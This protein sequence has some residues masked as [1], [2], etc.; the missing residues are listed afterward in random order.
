MNAT[1]FILAGLMFLISDP[2]YAFQIPDAVTVS[3]GEF[4]VSPYT[5]R[6][7][8]PFA[9]AMPGDAERAAQDWAPVFAA[10]KKT[11]RSDHRTQVMK[12]PKGYRWVQQS[13]GTLIAVPV[14]TTAVIRQGADGLKCVCRVS[15]LDKC[16]HLVE[17]DGGTAKCFSNSSGGCGSNDNCMFKGAPVPGSQLQ[18]QQ[19]PRVAQ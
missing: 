7:R 19:A 12:A 3:C 16:S 10:S 17:D 14:G 18:F 6:S 5:G 4:C 2:S 8:Q 1:G 15:G 13:N 9:H 11:K